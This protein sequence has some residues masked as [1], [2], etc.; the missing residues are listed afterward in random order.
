MLEHKGVVLRFF[1]L[2]VFLWCRDIICSLL[3]FFFIR[4]HTKTRERYG[5]THRSLSRSLS[6]SRSRKGRARREKRC[7]SEMASPSSASSLCRSC[8]VASMSSRVQRK[9][10]GV[11]R[12]GQRGGG[13]IERRRLRTGRV[14][15][16]HRRKWVSSDTPSLSVLNAISSDKATSSS[17]SSSSFDFDNENGTEED[18]ARTKKRQQQGTRR[19]D[20]V[21]V[22]EV[23]SENT[24]E[25]AIARIRETI[26]S[27][28]SS[29]DDATNSASSSNSECFG[30]DVVCPEMQT[31][32]SFCP[33]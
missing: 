10:D 14:P 22:R 2:S 23:S 3:K 1:F 13:S 31:R 8:C 15:P 19:L 6:L 11:A 5:E 27:E 17:S 18:E 12:G 7:E 26:E 28:C 16:R 30:L 4:S 20:V 29:T 21:R 25:N 24:I 33:R 9:G 32:C